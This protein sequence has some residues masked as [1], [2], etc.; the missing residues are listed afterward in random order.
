[1]CLIWEWRSGLLALAIQQ[2]E[3]YPLAAA[4]TTTTTTII[5]IINNHK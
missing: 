3:Y 2:G 1:M 4:T 5:I